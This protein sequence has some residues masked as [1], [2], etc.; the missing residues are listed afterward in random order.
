M[1]PVPVQSL[2]VNPLRAQNLPDRMHAQMD[3][4]SQ[5]L[6]GWMPRLLSVFRAARRSRGPAERL[7]PE[8]VQ[9]VARG[10]RRLSQGLTR[11]RRLVGARYLDDP[12]LLAVYLLYFWPISYAQARHAFTEM[13]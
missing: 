5:A 7:L 13:G 8:E 3:P 12:E 10:V 11:G 1:G 4:I 9:L 6:A 2:R